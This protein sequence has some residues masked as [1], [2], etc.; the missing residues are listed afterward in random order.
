MRCVTELTKVKVTHLTEEALLEQ[1]QA[2]IDALPKPKP[3]PATPPLQIQK[4]AQPAVPK[5][6]KEELYQ[7]DLWTRLLEMVRKGRMDA[8]KT[9]WE[10]Q[11]SELVGGVDGR[12]PDWL[13]GKDSGASGTLLQV[14]AASGQE[15]PTRWLLED[16]HA[17]PTVA[18][19]PSFTRFRNTDADD[20]V[21]AEMADEASSGQVAYDLCPN[22]PTRNV[23]RRC[24]YA[25]PDWWDWL[26][27][28]GVKSV[29][30]PEMEAKE[31]KKEESRRRMR[32]KARER[33]AANAPV[34]EPEHPAPLQATT[35]SKGPSDGP[36][37]L[38]GQGG[39]QEAVAGLTPEM[40]ARVE[41]ERRARA[42]EA[43]LKGL[44]G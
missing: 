7:R 43:R 34:E 25:H 20:A 33:E 41:R 4:V 11:G 39:S 19:P 38:G 21:T 8:L 15:D 14:A 3:R 12:L 5:L 32:E 31:R 16:L 37:K 23:F 36:Q 9:F 29:L 6:S 35:K 27:L 26:G 1:Y 42:A 10:K 17:N 22:A 2:M 28:A 18:V 24:A 13:E 30:T 40:R 44:Q